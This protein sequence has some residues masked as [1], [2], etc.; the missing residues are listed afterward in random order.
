MVASGSACEETLVADQLLEEECLPS[1]RKRIKRDHA[2][3]AVLKA[4]ESALHAS[5]SV[6]TAKLMVKQRQQEVCVSPNL[7]E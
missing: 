6:D 2:K 5:T 1:P 3:Q 4:A 7:D